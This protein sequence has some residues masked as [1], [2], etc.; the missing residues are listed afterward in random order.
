MAEGDL[1]RRKDKDDPPCLC[2][3]I[4]TVH[5]YAQEPWGNDPVRKCQRAE[6]LILGDYKSRFRKRYLDDRSVSYAGANF[7]RLDHIMAGFAKSIGN[8]R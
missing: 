8:D 7:R 2:R 4:E 5:G 3:R 6:V 1:V